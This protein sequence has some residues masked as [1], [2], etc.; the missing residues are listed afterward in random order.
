MAIF[1]IGDLHLSLGTQKPMDIFRG[2]QDYTKRLAENWRA[3]VTDCDTVVLAG[4]ISWAMKL[5]DC[6]AD[7]AFIHALPGKKLLLKGNH[8]YWWTTVSKMNA[9]LEQNAFH[10]L[11]FLFNN[12]YIEEGVA[13]CGT[14][15]WLFDEG[16]P[17][18]E[19]VMN[20]EVGRLQASLQAAGDAQ[21]LVFLHY[22][23]IFQGS[24][25]HEIIAVM[26]NYNVKQCFYGHLHSASIKSAT[27]GL[28]NGIDYKLISADAVNFCPY[29]ICF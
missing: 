28:Q 19:K 22:P 24:C 18:D 25:A 29:K 13:L 3:N 6:T 5:E 20:R 9:Y 21:K 14:R 12:C 16:A 7:F 8:D 4:D 1:V 2:W 10:S 23:P 26:Q 15:S 27:Q 11:H 17:H